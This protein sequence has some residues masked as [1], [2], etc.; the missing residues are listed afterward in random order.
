MSGNNSKTSLPPP[1]EMPES[2]MCCESGCGDACIFEIYYQ[3]KQAYEMLLRQQEAAEMAS[4]T[5]PN[6]DF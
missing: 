6:D 3:E 2:Y 1:P 5:T 4:K